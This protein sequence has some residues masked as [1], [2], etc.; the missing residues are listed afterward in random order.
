MNFSFTQFLSLLGAVG[1]FLYGMKVMSEGL[2]KAA[3]DRLRSILSAMTR[4]RFMGVITGVI[5]TAL[6][7]SSSASTVM[8]VSF[9][10]A[11]LMSL[12]Q[13][14]A[15]ILGANL[16][17]TFTTWIVSIFGFK[18]KMVAFCL[19]ILAV[20]VPML[21]LK[22][23]EWKSIGEFLIGFAFLFFGLDYINANV[24]QI[25]PTSPF[26]ASLQAYTQMGFWSL[27]IFFALGL[28][29]TMIIQSSAA[30]FAIVL[31]MGTQG[32]IN[33]DMGCAIILGGN[34][35]T[36]ITPLLASM[37]GN[38]AAKKAAMGHLVYNLI[39]AAWMLAIFFPFCKMIVWVTRD[40]VHA[41]EPTALYNAVASGMKPTAALQASMS[42]GL[43][44]YHTI[45]N[46]LS[47]LLLIGFTKQLVKV[48]NWLIKTKKEEDGF[49][50]KYISGGLMNA[51]ELNIAAAQREIAVYAERVERMLGMVKQLVHTK[52]GTEE[53]NQIYT[54][55]GKYEDIS[56]R[57]EIEIAN[58]L[59]M[60]I[61]GRLSH[62]AKMRISTM[63]NFVGEIESI[64]DSCNNI[65]RTLVRKEEAHAH[66]SEENYKNIDTM[67]KYVSEAMSNMI[68]VLADL[69][70]AT[71]ED[72]IRSYNK[73][74]EINNYRNLLRT[75]NIENIN[76][77]KYPYQAGIFYMDIVCEAEKV[78]DFIINVIEGVD[79][80]LRRHHHAASKHS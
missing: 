51:A 42:M 3:G 72:M 16:G 67:L 41:G 33:F 37:G 59:N 46:I 12:E 55:I 36:T 74:R 62:D 26:F 15:V 34:V 19:P 77:K 39:S 13:S 29:L 71:E 10:N 61:D 48:V 28:V 45:Y 24:P 60:V 8:V 17:S 63:L 54:R 7:Q 80:Q 11:G 21:F 49:S 20:G 43:T 35:G 32:W 27:L 6:I 40:L 79:E 9:V 65:A 66:F 53:F 31:V 5:I 30:T 68:A 52:T 25:D 14:M 76:Q 64:A 22:R 75:E 4:N 44:L 50:L 58:Y 2:Q 78:G 73:E 70:N 23:S 47:L 69:D 56:D 38:A 18:V 1:L 57:M